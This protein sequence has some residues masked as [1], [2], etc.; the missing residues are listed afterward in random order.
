MKR[1]SIL[2]LLLSAIVS[3]GAQAPCMAQDADYDHLT[4]GIYGTP[5][6]N[7][8]RLTFAMRDPFSSDPRFFTYKADPRILGLHAGS[9]IPAFGVRWDAATYAMILGEYGVGVGTALPEEA[10]HVFASDATLG[11]GFEDPGFDQ[12]RVLVENRFSATQVRTM[13]ELVNNGGARMTFDN[14]DSDET[15]SMMTNAIDNFNISLD[16]TGGAEFT[17]RQDGALKVGPGPVANFFLAPNGNL[18]IKGALNQ[19]SDRNQKEQF[20]DIDTARILESVVELPITSWSY[21]DDDS[22]RHI[23]PMSQ[24]FHDAFQLGEDDRVISA[25]DA[26]GIAL[27]A[28]QELAARNA[29]LES[30]VDELRE[31]VMRLE[32]VVLARD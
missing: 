11:S 24:D 18:T 13:L 26:D 27:A 14:Y 22:V 16:G 23:G 9:T 10:L 29:D 20:E 32:R 4:L 17:L 31:M 21:K 8:P 1:I 7:N 19:Q 3:F 12:A 25:I 28:I 5:G 2:T 30:E 15:W 6:N